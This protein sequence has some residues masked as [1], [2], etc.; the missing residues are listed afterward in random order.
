MKIKSQHPTK[1][2]I[3]WILALF[4]L[5]TFFKQSSQCHIGCLSCSENAECLLCDKLNFFYLNADNKKCEHNFIENCIFAEDPGVC[6]Y[7]EMGFF[8]DSESQKCDLLAVEFQKKNCRSHDSEKN[9]IL[10][11]PEYKLLEKECLYDYHQISNCSDYDSEN[12]KCQ[13]CEPGF[14]LSSD[15][16]HCVNLSQKNCLIPKYFSCQECSQNYFPQE[17]NL[18]SSL[19]NS[20]LELS[21]AILLSSYS[22]EYSKKIFQTN[23]TSLFSKKDFICEKTQLSNC[24]K[25]KTISECQ[26][27]FDSFILNPTTGKCEPVIL[28]E[29]PFCVKYY[30]RGACSVCQDNYFKQSNMECIST[31]KIDFCEEYAQAYD[32]CLKCQEEYKLSKTGAANTCQERT[33]FPISNCGRF[34]YFLISKNYTIFWKK[35]VQSVRKIMFSLQMVYFVI[36]QYRI[37]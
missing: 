34:Y 1:N 3:K 33:N 25:L 18:Y 20:S 29:I 14:K 17:S 36:N 37:A 26:E 21:S 19:N 4:L 8:W 22:I 13:K 7:C 35:S 11:L 12:S 23:T 10:C 2:S 5:L 24:K 6:K 31:F 27:C 32:G 30:G 9:C 15:E 16:K 28:S